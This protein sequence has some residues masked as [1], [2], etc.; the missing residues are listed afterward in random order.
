[1]KISAILTGH[2]T[3]NFFLKIAVES[4]LFLADIKANKSLE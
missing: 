2:S 4:N 3:A 1:M